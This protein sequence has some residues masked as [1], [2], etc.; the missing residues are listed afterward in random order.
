MIL[1]L[2]DIQN[3]EGK[4]KKKQIKISIPINLRNLYPTRTMRNFSSYTNIGIETKYGNY[5][6]EEITKIIKSTMELKNS[7]KM[8]NSKITANVKL[9][10]NYF[11][12]LVP[13]FKKNTYYQHLNS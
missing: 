13:M 11:I 12:R 9:S 1:A 7:E 4:K 8:I 2:Q 5:T 6:F 3:M 10:K